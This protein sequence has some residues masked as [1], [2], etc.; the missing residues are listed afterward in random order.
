VRTRLAA[1]VLAI[2]AAALTACGSDEE[3][4]PRPTTTAAAAPSAT[5][6]AAAT[7]SA[8]PAPTTTT[9]DQVIRATVVGGQVTPPAGVVDVRLGSTVVLEVTVDV[10]DELHVHGYDRTLALPA[11]QPARLELAAVIP[12]QFEVEL[13]EGGRLLFT[14]RVS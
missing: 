3:P 12:G 10:A 9:A 2:A 5:E 11:G 13:H 8:T 7:V 4:A 6:S 14:L 1:A